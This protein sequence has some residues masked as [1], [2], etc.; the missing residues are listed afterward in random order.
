MSDLP[1]TLM[2][3][4]A[5]TVPTTFN[6]LLFGKPKSG[7]STAA[8]TA[9][10]PILWV[11]AEG[12]GALGYARKV[13]AQ[14]NTVIHEVMIGNKAVTP[15][16][17]AILEAVYKHVRDGAEPQV[18]T[19]VID[20]LAKVRDALIAQIVVKSSKNSLPQYGEVAD[21]LGGF[22]NALRDLPV[23]LVLLAHVDVKDGEDGRIVDPLI[24]GALT[25]KVPGEVDVVSYTLAVPDETG[26]HRYY[27]QVVEGRGRT[28]GDRSGGL[29]A[30]G[31]IR[32]LDL[33][34]WLETYRAALTPDDSDLP[35]PAGVPSRAR[36]SAPARTSDQGDAPSAPEPTEDPEPPELVAGTTPAPTP[37]PTD[38]AQAIGQLKAAGCICPDPL[39]FGSET[40]DLDPVCPLVG[41]GQPLLAGGGS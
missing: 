15:N 32:E 39:A 17:A 28:C 27:G 35:F 4:P 29:A 18:Q 24:G 20:T 10:G 38:P 9:P 30:D 13:A 16:P 2:F 21:K 36:A 12:P 23:N 1:A 34:E 19:V 37:L 41:H 14:R 40:P 26:G 8:A 6:V 3:A 31:S 5:P 33:S 25:E 11:N 22:I 7:K